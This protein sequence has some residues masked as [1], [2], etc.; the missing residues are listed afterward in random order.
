[1]TNL[2]DFDVFS[3]LLQKLNDS[4]P[5]QLFPGI[6][7]S[8]QKSIHR[9]SS[10]VRCM[11]QNSCYLYD[12][13]SDEEQT[14]NRV[15]SR[16]ACD[17]NMPTLIPSHEETSFLMKTFPHFPPMSVSGSPLLDISCYN[18][19]SME[20]ELT[21]EFPIP[22]Q[23]FE[24]VIWKEIESTK[25][26]IDI[27]EAEVVDMFTILQ[28]GLSSLVTELGTKKLMLYQFGFIYILN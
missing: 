3:E 28:L 4:V 18:I 8:L 1:M 2:Q 14:C 10:V 19:K 5:P 15:L 9:I 12:T 13:D 23:S 27:P 6:C 22:S 11:Q 7:S 21:A 26:G 24:D 17:R 25:H 20:Q 16:L